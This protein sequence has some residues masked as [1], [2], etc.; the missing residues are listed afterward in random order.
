VVLRKQFGIES[1]LINEFE[2]VVYEEQISEVL[3]KQ[4]DKKTIVKR[5]RCNEQ[6]YTLCTERKLGMPLRQGNIF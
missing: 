4:E 1:A 6:A 3:K 2:T 5:I